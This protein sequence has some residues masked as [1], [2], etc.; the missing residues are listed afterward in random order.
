MTLLGLLGPLLQLPPLDGDQEVAGLEEP[1][2]EHGDAVEQDGGGEGKRDEHALAVEI[3][4][5]GVELVVGCKP[6]VCPLCS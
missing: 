5:L 3:L 1:V 2:D 4:L 6:L